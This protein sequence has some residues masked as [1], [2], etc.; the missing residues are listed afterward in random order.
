MSRSFILNHPDSS[1]FVVD[2]FHVNVWTLKEKEVYVDVGLLLEVSPDLMR[3]KLKNFSLRTPFAVKSNSVQDLGGLMLSHPSLIR[4][5][6][7]DNIAT[8]INVHKDGDRATLLQF[9]LRKTIVLVQSNV[10]QAGDVIN[11]SFQELDLDIDEII[12]TLNFPSKMC[13][14]VRLRFEIDLK[15]T[16]NLISDHTMA[17]HRLMYDFRF[18]ER[19]VMGDVPSVVPDLIGIRNIYIFMIQPIRYK[20]VLKAEGNLRYMRLLENSS[21]SWAA[22]LPAL[23]RV[24]GRFLVYSWKGDRSA[25]PLDA[26]RL[27]VAFERLSRWQTRGV[28][29]LVMLSLLQALLLTL[30]SINIASFFQV[31]TPYVTWLLAVV[32]TVIGIALA[33][34]IGNMLWDSVKA[35]YRR[36]KGN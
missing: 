17:Y 9:Q 6:F 30:Q 25:K 21:T 4:L 36:F 32:S 13:L 1:E 35:I 3:G 24:R 2:E 14:Y 29:I 12:L 28:L 7:N 8:Q 22:Y 23:K 31:T 33:G 26:F 5:L 19:R 34:A 27:L 15:R 16:E 20:V 10:S 18:N 11:L